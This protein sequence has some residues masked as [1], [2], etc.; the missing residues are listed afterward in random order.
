M[1]RKIRKDRVF[2]ITQILL[3]L[4]AMPAIV[5]NQT[6]RRGYFAIGGE[7][8]IIPLICL[9]WILTELLKEQLLITTNKER[10]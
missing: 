1:K 7:W 5:M 6:T 9:V 4:M 10:K 8:L 2:F 3:V